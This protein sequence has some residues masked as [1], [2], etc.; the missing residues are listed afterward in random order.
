MAR[1][2]HV[3]D[4]AGSFPQPCA[5][6]VRV[7]LSQLNHWQRRQ[8]Q[9]PLAQVARCAIF[10]LTPTQSTFC[11]ISSPGRSGLQEAWWQRA[12]YRTL[13]VQ[14]SKLAGPELSSGRTKGLKA[15]GAR[16]IHTD[17]EADQRQTPEVG[18][19]ALITAL[20]ADSPS[21]CL[22][23]AATSDY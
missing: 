14:T 11:T 13:H 8:R 4:K 6:N 18:I 19:R 2:D 23:A 21:I 5:V 20:F 1:C 12:V 22:Y 3:G 17:P 7:Y 9:V 10:S 15:R 16:K